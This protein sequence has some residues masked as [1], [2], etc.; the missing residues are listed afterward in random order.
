MYSTYTTKKASIVERFNRTLKSK[1]WKR[2]SMNGS[3]RWVDMLQSL[4][5]EYNDSKHRTIKMKPNNVTISNEKNLLDSIYNRKWVITPAVKPKFHVGDTVRLSKYKHIFEKG[6]T[7][8]WTTEVFK[9]KK[10]QYTDPITY[11]LVDLN[12]GEIKGTI[13]AEELQLVK[14]PNIYLVER[15]IRSIG[16]K[17]FVKWLG[18]DSSH[19]S[20]IDE[21]EML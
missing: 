8:N 21:V 5:N 4:L 9:I 16:N 17:V 7:P 14:N 6:Y 20:W 10:I 2:F 13:Y 12:D 3:Y 18:F 19:N 1:M 15:I 11:K